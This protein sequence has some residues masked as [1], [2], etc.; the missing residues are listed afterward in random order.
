MAIAYLQALLMLKHCVSDKQKRSEQNRGEQDGAN[1]LR[2]DIKGPV[3][4]YRS[5]QCIGPNKGSVMA[6]LNVNGLRSHQDEKKLL[7]NGLMIDILALNEII[8][9]S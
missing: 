7:M 4:G 8:L 9:D 3:T 2:F 6:P 1:I 5:S